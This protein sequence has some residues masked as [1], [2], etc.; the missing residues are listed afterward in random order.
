MQLKRSKEI[1]ME[2][3]RKIVEKCL[4]INFP[5]F[6]IHKNSSLCKRCAF[7]SFISSNFPGDFFSQ[8]F[9]IAFAFQCTTSC[10][11][12]STLVNP[13]KGKNFM[14][15]NI[16]STL[17]SFCPQFISAILISIATRHLSFVCSLYYAIL[18]LV[19]HN[20]NPCELNTT[21]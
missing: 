15:Q 5:S 13:K 4:I 6:A 21:N 17:W 1:L 19:H 12:S 16:N 18:I 7:P 3:S 9:I 14:H 20:R 11:M 10:K 2:I 8:K